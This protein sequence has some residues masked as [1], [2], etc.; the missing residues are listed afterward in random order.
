MN[1][2]TPCSI[3]KPARAT[4]SGHAESSNGMRAR[5]ARTATLAYAC[6]IALAKPSLARCLRRDR[7]LTNQREPI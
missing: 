2:R 1:G 7:V 6:L 5:D 3:S 4:R